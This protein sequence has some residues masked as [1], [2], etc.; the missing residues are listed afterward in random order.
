MSKI[1]QLA[2]AVQGSDLRAAAIELRNLLNEW[3]PSVSW[4]ELLLEFS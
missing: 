1:P 2:N 4:L 3:V